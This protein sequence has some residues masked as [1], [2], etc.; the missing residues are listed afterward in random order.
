MS[1]RMTLDEYREWKKT[2]KHLETQHME[3]DCDNEHVIWAMEVFEKDGQYYIVECDHV[4]KKY[5]LTL[6][7]KASWMEYRCEYF[8][9]D[10]TELI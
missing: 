6:A 1:Q 5:H 10:G 7:K 9:A 4:D 8:P 3:W 2:A